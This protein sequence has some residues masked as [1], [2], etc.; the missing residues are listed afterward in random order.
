[1]YKIINI[2]KILF[3]EQR[4]II[5]PQKWIIYSKT[6]WLSDDRDI[7]K[8]V[9]IILKVPTCKV[10]LYVFQISIYELSKKVVKGKDMWS[11]P[12]FGMIWI[13]LHLTKKIT[14]VLRC[15]R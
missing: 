12:H 13:D 14:L 8:V 11:W 6:L 15:S 9:W 1:M 2:D 3:T 4:L 7:S 10:L 5:Y